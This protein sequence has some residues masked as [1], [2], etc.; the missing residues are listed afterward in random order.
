MMTGLDNDDTDGRRW[1]R[2]RMV[3]RMMMVTE[4]EDG[5]RDGYRDGGW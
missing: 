2:W 3:T 5:N 4:M 1:H